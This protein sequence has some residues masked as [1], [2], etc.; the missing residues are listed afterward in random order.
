MV[1]RLYLNKAVN[2]AGIHR[3]ETGREMTYTHGNKG[4]AAPR[5]QKATIHPE[6]QHTSRRT[7]RTPSADSHAG[8]MQAACYH[9]S[10]TQ[11]SQDESLR[12]PRFHIIQT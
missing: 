12:T 6:T 7:T 11:H 5:A 1:C 2:K 9:G 4:H 10:V 8:G 3:Y